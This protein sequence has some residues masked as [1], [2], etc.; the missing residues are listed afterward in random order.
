MIKEERLSKVKEN[1][2]DL[3]SL[4]HGYHPASK[5]G[6]RNHNMPITAPGPEVACGVARE[7]IR[8]EY[9]GKH[10]IEKFHAAVESG[11]INVIYSLL[12]DT[13]FGVPESTSCWGI[14]GFAVAVDLMDDLPEEM[15]T[16]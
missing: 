16:D 12:S 7:R 4:I 2:D 14:Q 1:K 11:D 5:G 3:A 9:E 6:I 8:A 10:P 15:Y 13:W